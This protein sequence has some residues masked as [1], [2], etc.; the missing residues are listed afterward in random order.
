MTRRACG[1]RRRGGSPRPHPPPMPTP[2]VPPRVTRPTDRR[3][4]RADGITDW[5]LRHGAVRRTS[6]DTYLPLCDA[7]DL[8]QR[9]RA[10]L[11]GAPANA[12]VSHQTAASLFGLQIPMVPEDERVHL[13]VPPPT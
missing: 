2:P 3:S 7:P 8:L 13:T 10:V 9:V 1:W 6:R 11:M 5:H 12:L 4:A